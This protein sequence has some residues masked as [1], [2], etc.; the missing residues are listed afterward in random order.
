MKQRTLRH[1]SGALIAG[2]L[3]MFAAGCNPGA[4]NNTTAPRN[5]A[6]YAGAPRAVRPA[7]H[8]ILVQRDIADRVVRVAHVQAASVLVAGNTAYVGVRLQPGVH[9]GLAQRVKN[10]IISTVKAAHPG[11]TT[12]FVSANPDVFLHLQTFANDIAQGRP[13]EAVW[14]NFQ[15]FVRRVWPTAR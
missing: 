12:V 1:A 4:N 6:G 10:R 11:I 3:L 8:R 13:V 9:T 2:S 5:A 7:D 14:G 15:S